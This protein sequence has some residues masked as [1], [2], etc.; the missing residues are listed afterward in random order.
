VNLL[1]NALEHSPAGGRIE[2]V[3]GSDASCGRAAV[4]DHGTGIP[5]ALLPELFTR[6]RSSKATGHGI[7]LTLSRRILRSH[8]GDLVHEATPSGGATFTLR[9][10]ASP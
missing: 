9:F 6:F 3:C 5:A 4:I 7:G 1:N 2:I 10:P 8:G